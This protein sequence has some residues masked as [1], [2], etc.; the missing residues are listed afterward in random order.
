M[1]SVA[2]VQTSNWILQDRA[3]RLRMASLIGLGMVEFQA[4]ENVLTYLTEAISISKSIPSA[5]YPNVAVSAKIDA[6]RGL[7]RYSEAL[8]LC[9]EAIRI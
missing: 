3:G 1:P 9:A 7:R 5:A 6:L 4:C 2:N 8:A